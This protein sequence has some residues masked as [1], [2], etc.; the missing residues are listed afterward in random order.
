MAAYRRDQLRAQRSVTSMGELYLYLLLTFFY[1]LT[2]CSCN[3]SVT[4]CKPQSENK[5]LIVTDRIDILQDT[6][7]IPLHS[8]F[9]T[10]QTI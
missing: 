6:E 1:L 4:T 5:P 7:T 10:V 8:A 2:R 9:N 3:F